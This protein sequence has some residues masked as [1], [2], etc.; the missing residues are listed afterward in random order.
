M[1]EAMIS[2]EMMHT[3]QKNKIIVIGCDKPRYFEFKENR[4]I[5]N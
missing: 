2:D 5:L 4:T 3:H 1:Y